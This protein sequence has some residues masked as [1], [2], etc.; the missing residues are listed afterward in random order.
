MQLNKSELG[1]DSSYRKRL[2]LI[3]LADIVCIAF[4][5]L[6]ALWVRFDFVLSN[7][8]AKYLINLTW[9]IPV[10]VLISIFVYYFMRLYHSI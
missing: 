5:Y 8:E 3:V 6:F 10:I 4:S 2:L 9:F 1:K 7:I